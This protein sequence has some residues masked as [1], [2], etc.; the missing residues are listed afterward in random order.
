[1]T[2]D[3]V[4]ASDT[5]AAIFCP[6][7]RD[8][9]PALQYRILSRGGG[10]DGLLRA[11]PLP[12]GVSIVPLPM[13]VQAPLSCPVCTSWYSDYLGYLS[14]SS[15]GTLVGPGQQQRLLGLHSLM[16]KMA[17]SLCGWKERP[18]ADAQTSREHTGPWLPGLLLPYNSFRQ[19]LRAPSN[20]CP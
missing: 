2:E 13:E 8:D 17:A 5:P 12:V 19:G 18:P 20:C 14:W 11:A 4:H 15:L 9:T 10:G 6:G 7:C 1:M 3:D 16:A